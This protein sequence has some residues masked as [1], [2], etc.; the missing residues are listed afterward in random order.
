MPQNERSLKRHERSH[1]AWNEARSVVSSR[2]ACGNRSAV[3]E[4]TCRFGQAFATIH[5]ERDW[6]PVLLRLRAEFDAYGVGIDTIKK[7]LNV[8]YIL[9]ALLLGG[10]GAESQR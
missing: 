10:R 2:A 4:G 1:V 9:L 3:G 8:K 7:N 5:S 6:V